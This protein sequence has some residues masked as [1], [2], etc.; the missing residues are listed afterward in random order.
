MS[1]IFVKTTTTTGWKKATNIFVKTTT[2]TGW[3]AAVAVWIK[4]ATQ[5]LKVWP[6]SGIFATRVPF[7]ADFY[8]D[9]YAN[10]FTNASRIRIGTSYFGN[11]AIWDLNGFGASSY[12]YEWNLYDELG[13]YL[14]R[15][16]K[17][18]SAWSDVAPTSEGNGKDELLDSIWTATNST[19]SDLQYLGFQVTANSS[20][21]T[22]YNGVAVSSKIKVIREI[23]LNESASLTGTP[24]VGSTLSFGSAWNTTQAYKIDATRTT[25]AWYKSLSNTN[26]YS[27]GSRVEITRA[28]GSYSITIQSTDNLDGYYVIAE[29]SV[30]NSG[31]D[32]DLGPSV[33]V[34]GQNQVTRVTA[35][36]VITPLVPPTSL[37]SAVGTGSIVMTFAGGTGAQYDLYYANTNSRQA[38]GAAYADASNIVSPYNAS[39]A[40]PG[41]LGLT[42]RNLTRYFWIRKSTGGLYSSWYP[43]GAT[44]SATG[45]SAR[46]P[47]L[48]PNAP[49]SPTTSGITTTNITFSWTA[50]AAADST[51]DAVASYDYY[52]S[53]TNSIPATPT[54]NTTGTSVS[55]TYTASTTPVTQYFWVKAKGA[56]PD[57][58]TS[59]EVT[60]SATPTALVN[61]RA[62][63][64]MRRVTMP[65]SF[66]NSSQS[67]WVGTN[68]YVSVT[69]DPTTS[70]GTSWPS[71]GG[72]VVG[73]AVADMK[74]VSLFTLADASNYYVRWRGH[75][76]SEAASSITIDYLMK[77]YWNSAT[78]DVYFITNS[79]TASLSTSSIYSGGSSYSLW[80]NSTLITG[81]SIPS[82][83]VQDTTLAAETDDDRTAITATKPLLNLTTNPAYG[84]ATSTSGGWTASITTSPNPTGGTYSVV[85][86][87]VGSASVNSSTGALTASGLT[88]GQSSTVTVRYSLSGY[89]SVDITK[90]GTATTTASG[91][92]V[93]STS[94]VPLGNI[95]TQYTSASSNFTGGIDDG[96]WTFTLPFATK[97]NGT[98]Y[99]TMYVGTNSYITFGAGSTQFSSLGA[100]NPPNNKVMVY[101]GDRGSN[102]VYFYSTG[103]GGVWNIKLN[104]GLGTS[105][106]T[107]IQWELYSSAGTSTAVDVTIVSGS[108]GTTMAASATTSF[109]SLGGNGT[110]WRITSQ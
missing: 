36:A 26:I 61:V 67:I 14:G 69:V 110:A 22:T 20:S 21:G 85:S 89:N 94:Y 24:A 97:F 32:N 18:G 100:A 82:G 10:R 41:G 72:V 17:S 107:D 81:M 30:F 54:G 74:Q 6:T 11:N 9:T 4:N 71:A 92:T 37:T 57:F 2:T 48:A 3:K 73:P 1:D 7:I 106:G 91:P 62:T 64:A 68:G 105:A 50:S 12:S 101:A 56:T 27:G 40:T 35:S 52:T 103:A 59:A 90:T 34:N 98:N 19:N 46:L 5:W 109:S 78:V 66:T 51:H 77:F 49:T 93:T 23:P 84:A 86:Q 13:I 15:T 60:T 33:A 43:A 31:S 53:N 55:F 95:G 96:Y 47:L 28:F 83:M 104:C 29:Q 16:L 44:G 75:G 88:S 70:P 45:V 80:D 108:G 102:S 63:G 39:A 76:Y 8:S 42:G 79:T 58:A 65:V 38:D 25:I 99:T 87:T